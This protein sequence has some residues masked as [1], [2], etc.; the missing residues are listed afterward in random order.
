[1]STPVFL[2]FSV[3]LFN[4]LK[5]IANIN[6]LIFRAVCFKQNWVEDIKIFHIIF[7]SFMHRLPF[8][9]IPHQNK[10]FTI[11]DEPTMTYNHPKSTAYSWYCTFY[12]FRQIYNDIYL[13]L[14]YHEK[15]THYPKIPVRFAYSSLLQPPW[16]T[17]IFLLSP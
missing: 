9:N 13:I 12:G 3:I 15:Q 4:T 10:M 8:T 11:N 5:N 1:M 7:P 6:I 14:Y 16:K 2:S 17:L